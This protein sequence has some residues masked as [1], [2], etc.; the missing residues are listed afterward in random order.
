[1][2]ARQPGARMGAG[3]CL[4]APSRRSSPRGRL[5]HSHRT[6]RF[7][8]DTGLPQI[9]QRGGWVLAI[10]AS[11]AVGVAQETDAQKRSRGVMCTLTSKLYRA[12]RS[13]SMFAIEPSGR[14]LRER[15]R[16]PSGPVFERST[17]AASRMRT[18][19]GTAAACRPMQD[20]RHDRPSEGSAVAMQ[21]SLP[22]DFRGATALAPG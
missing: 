13:N 14:R 1:M 2:N 21:P 10:M 3:P 4:L 8:A 9:A 11:S 12:S 5:S 15:T 16:P 22:V 17:R 7:Q 19:L 6:C 20:S 18:A